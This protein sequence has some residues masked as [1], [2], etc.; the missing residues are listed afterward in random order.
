MCRTQDT[1]HRVHMQSGR[2]SRES[3]GGTEA[4]SSAGA[5]QRRSAHSTSARL[6][7]RAHN[8]HTA[9]CCTSPLS[10][11]PHTHTFPFSPATAVQ[12]QRQRSAG[13]RRRTHFHPRHSAGSSAPS[14]AAGTNAGLSSLRVQVG[15]QRLQPWPHVTALLRRPQPRAAVA[16]WPSSA[17]LPF[18]ASPCSAASRWWRIALAPGFV[19]PLCRIASIQHARSPD[20]RGFSLT[21]NVQRAAA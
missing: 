16:A 2:S 9:L 17:L 5:T 4:E 19:K 3:S 12:P 21:H 8:V 7:M 1:G 18:Y 13:Q 10:A 11:A 6:R 20:T 15:G 14:G